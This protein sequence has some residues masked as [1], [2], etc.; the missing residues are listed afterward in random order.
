MEMDRV[1]PHHT[2]LCGHAGPGRPLSRLGQHWGRGGVQSGPRGHPQII[3]LQGCATPQQGGPEVTH[4][5]T[6]CHRQR[7]R[8]RDPQ[9]E[10]ERG[11]WGRAPLGTW[12]RRAGSTSYLGLECFL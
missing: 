3:K 2:A 11:E 10:R 12:G 5:H 6:R 1:G 4:C 7:R 8:H 9:T